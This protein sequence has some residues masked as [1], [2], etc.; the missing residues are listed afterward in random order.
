MSYVLGKRAA[1]QIAKTIRRVQ[2]MP[3]TAEP[4]KRRQRSS[5]G[6]RIWKAKANEPITAGSTAGEVS[7]YEIDSVSGGTENDTGQDVDARYDWAHNSTDLASGDEV[8]VYQQGET[9]WI[10]GREC[11]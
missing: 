3:I 2:A 7:L 4:V 5:T 1:E 11:P 10:I 8:L 6:F 9:Y